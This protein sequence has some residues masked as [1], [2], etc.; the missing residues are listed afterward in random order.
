MEQKRNETGPSKAE[1]P[2]VLLG[3]APVVEQDQAEGFPG[4]SQVVARRA[5]DAFK[6]AW[7]S[8]NANQA[9]VHFLEAKDK[10]K[11][12][13]NY[14]HLRDRPFRDLLALLHAAILYAALDDLGPKQRDVLQLAFADLPQ[15]FLKDS[16]VEQ[17][18]D[19]FAQHDL[20]GV[21]G[22]IRQPPEKRVDFTIKEID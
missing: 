18:I 3:P 17:Y 1:T 7:E 16:L 11:D 20:Q 5:R 14:A 13:W 6:E 10:L 15:L 9:A 22:P 12:L 4:A 21:V 19:C 2:A 8:T